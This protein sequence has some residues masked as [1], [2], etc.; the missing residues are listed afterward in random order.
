[1]RA[2]VRE[3]CVTGA[4]HQMDTQELYAV[5]CEW[6]EARGH[7]RM[8]S[9]TFGADLFALSEGIRDGGTRRRWPAARIRHANPM[10]P[11][12]PLCHPDV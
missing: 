1:V 2:F 6:A 9:S 8:N 12:L 4:E 11:A 3:M 10:S 7:R 5:F